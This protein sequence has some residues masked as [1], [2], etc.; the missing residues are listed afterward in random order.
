MRRVAL[1][2]L[3]IVAPL[4]AQSGR[5]SVRA[6]LMGRVPEAA[7]AVVDSV[8]RV[9][10]GERLPTEPLVQKALE[11][12]AKHAAPGRIVQ[13]VGAQAEQ[14]RQARTLLERGGG[15]PPTAIEITSVAA[16]MVR[17][18]PPPLAGRIVTALPDEPPGPALH[19]VADLEGHGFAEDAAVD[20]IV[21]AA[22]AGLRGL[23]LLDV[24]TAAVHELQR[25][26]THPA[27]LATVR[28]ALPDVPWPPK[29][30][31]AEVNR[32]RRPRP[33]V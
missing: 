21:A 32:A 25:G 16:A 23:R 13:A 14:L 12:A 7:I 26:A 9:A 4:G 28:R 1:F 24:A 8:V 6:R 19:A 11:G 18:L 5:G 29:P 30:S 2:L 20:L 33:G 10:E 15:T 17:G 3:V 27:A 22:R 31:P